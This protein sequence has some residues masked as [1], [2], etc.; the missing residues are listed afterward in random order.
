MNLE[1]KARIQS[2]TD[3]EIASLAHAAKI[4]RERAIA[5]FVLAPD[6]SILDYDDVDHPLHRATR[7]VNLQHSLESI[8]FSRMTEGVKI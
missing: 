2:K 1:L 3:E 6:I 5:E 8:L 4:R 7:W